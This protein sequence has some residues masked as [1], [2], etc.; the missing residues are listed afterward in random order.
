MMRWIILFSCFS[1]SFL[2][3]CCLLPQ[4]MLELVMLWCFVCFGWGFLAFAS[5][6]PLMLPLLLLRINLYSFYY[7]QGS[8]NGEGWEDFSLCHFFICFLVLLWFRM[9]WKKS[10]RE[11]FTRFIF[12]GNFSIINVSPAKNK[13][14][15][16]SENVQQIW[17]MVSMLFLSTS[18]LWDSQWKRSSR[19]V[20]DQRFPKVLRC[21]RILPKVFYSFSE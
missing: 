1:F 20:Q 8:R 19:L 17:G 3:Y 21:L 14:H 9:G 10:L 18:Y 2:L 11:A 5:P 15:K 7:T 6:S 12:V 13:K 16:T 4:L